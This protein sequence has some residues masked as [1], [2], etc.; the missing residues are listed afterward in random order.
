MTQPAGPTRRPS[1]IVIAIL[2]ALQFVDGID[3]VA[4]SIVAPFLRAELGMGFGALGA[5]F[6][7]GFIGTALGAILFGTLA[8]RADRKT[9]VCLAATCFAV[10]SLTTIWV[11]NGT[12]LFAIRLVTGL[13]MGGLYPVVTALAME[14]APTRMRATAATLVS[15][16]TTI[17]AASCGP[18]VAVL[19]P[20][21]GWRSI[22]MFGSIVPVILV[23]LAM[24]LIPRS[25]PRRDPAG[26]GRRSG[27]PF[28]SVTTLFEGEYRRRTPILWLAFISASIPMFFTLSWLPTLAHEAGVA[29]G[30][31]SVTSSIFTVAGVLAAIPLARAIDRFGLTMLVVT[32]ALGAAALVVLGQA[33]GD[34]RVL[35]VACALAGACTVASVNLMGAVAAMLY[36]DS[37]RARGVGWA[38]AVMRMGAALAPALGG[39]LIAW[40]MPVGAVFLAFAIFP[41]VSAVALMQLQSGKL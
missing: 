1:L 28:R 17:G 33:F 25:P 38:V 16:A 10:G 39:S 34:P 29:P 21:F 32:S 14:S 31:A 9:T 12:E 15:I 5:S 8:D 7:A 37:L 13:A 3:Q 4:L 6:T 18:L 11:R 40:Q 2:F 26:K 30:V 27:N 41:I 36:G 24:L 35:L 23:I 19:R 20:A 22:F